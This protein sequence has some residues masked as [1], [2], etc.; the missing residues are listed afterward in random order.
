MP[1]PFLEALRGRLA[2]VFNGTVPLERKKEIITNRAWLACQGP[3]QHS[4]HKHKSSTQIFTDICIYIASFENNIQ[5]MALKWRCAPYTFDLVR[6]E[7]YT[8]G[9]EERGN[10]RSLKTSYD[11]KTLDS[12]NRNVWLLGYLN[13]QTSFSSFTAAM[14]ENLRLEKGWCVRVRVCTCIKMS[15]SE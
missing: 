9:K 7:I 8:K 14:S 10:L 11:H 6:C 2:P 1:I 13:Y 5:Y 15:N 12:T 3:W 4:R